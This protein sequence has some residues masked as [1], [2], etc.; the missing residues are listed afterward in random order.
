MI[1]DISLAMVLFSVRNS[2][3]AFDKLNISVLLS[4][5]PVMVINFSDFT[6]LLVFLSVFFLIV[7]LFAIAV[8][9]FLISSSLFKALSFESFSLLFFF[10]IL[11]LFSLFAFFLLFNYFLSPVLLRQIQSAG[12]PDF[13]GLLF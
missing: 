11:P 8:L 9:I 12:D 13:A 5:S 2:I 1:F 10:P 6:S 7:V 4:I 3:E